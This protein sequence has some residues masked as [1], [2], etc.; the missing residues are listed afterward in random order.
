MD[1]LQALKDER[2]RL[3]TAIL[4]L[5]G[6]DG[7]GRRARVKAGNGRRGGKRRLSAAAKK[8][9]SIA[10]KARWAKAKKAGRNS[11]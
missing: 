1:I 4:A 3:N 10:A 8:R 11:L 6:T 5:T 9:I 7:H 2:E